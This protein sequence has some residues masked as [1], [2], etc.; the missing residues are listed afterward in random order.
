[1]LC[2]STLVML[3]E[4]DPERAQADSLLR[5]R[6]LVEGAPDNTFGRWKY[7]GSTPYRKSTGAIVYAHG[8]V[9]EDGTEVLGVPASAGW[10]PR[11]QPTARRRVTPPR[12]SLRLVSGTSVCAAAANRAGVSSVR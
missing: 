6:L 1:M 12:G 4:H 9:H 7:L 5:T 10:W 11:G 8:F 2:I 3:P